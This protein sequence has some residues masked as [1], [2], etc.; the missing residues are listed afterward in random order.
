[1]LNN[2]TLLKETTKTQNN[3]SSTL[4]GVT[5]WIIFGVLLAG[6]LAIFIF[7]TIKDAINRKKLK[8]IRI[9]N[10]ED[11]KIFN[12]Y[13]LIYMNK[14][15]GIN[16][17]YLDE[18]QPSI[19]QYKMNQIINGAKNSLNELIQT[20]GFKN[21]IK[22]GDLEQK[23]L[24]DQINSLNSMRSNN[25]EKKNYEAINFFKSKVSSLDLSLYQEEVKKA[26]KIISNF[27]NEEIAK[28]LEMEE[29]DMSENLETEKKENNEEQ[30]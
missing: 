9:K 23:Q 8:K 10:E 4:S 21:L 19:G 11:M 28:T 27:Y 20:E 12:A 13:A 14:L 17:K 26:D 5:M 3:G 25:W 16:Q 7:A 15:I 6:M 24:I 18:F 29:N 1:M 2:L 30:Q 22:N